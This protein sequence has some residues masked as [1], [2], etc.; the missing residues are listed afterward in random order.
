[1]VWRGDNST[2]PLTAAVCYIRWDDYVSASWLNLQCRLIEECDELSSQKHNHLLS[3]ELYRQ[4]ESSCLTLN[5]EKYKTSRLWPP[6]H[7]AMRRNQDWRT[8]QSLVAWGKARKCDSKLRLRPPGCWV[9][10]PSHR[11]PPA[12][13]K[14]SVAFPRR[15]LLLLPLGLSRPRH[16]CCRV[17]RS[18]QRFPSLEAEGPSTGRSRPVEGETRARTWTAAKEKEECYLGQKNALKRWKIIIWNVF[19]P[20][21]WGS[22]FID[23][24]G[25]EVEVA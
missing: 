24:K 25:T 16:P 9:V 10:Q 5:I 20:Y 13:G 7:L 8:Y 12:P 17:E 4:S 11:S 19:I 6:T 1:M 3:Q 21:P 18:L 22:I 14:W 2:K 23:H 15:C